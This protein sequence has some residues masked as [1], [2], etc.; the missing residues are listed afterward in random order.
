MWIF[1]H[2]FLN[3][4]FNKF[5]LIPIYHYVLRSWWP[6]W[7]F[8]SSCFLDNVSLEKIHQ[9]RCIRRSKLNHIVR[10]KSKQQ[11]YKK[12]KFKNVNVNLRNY[13]RINFTFISSVLST[14]PLHIEIISNC[15]ET[16]IAFLLNKCVES[17][18]ICLN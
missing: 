2:I 10:N 14:E 12:I 3:S 11:V 5:L 4:D 15:S 13:M 9:I 1:I 17:R 6:S 18:L 16:L 8:I 7:L